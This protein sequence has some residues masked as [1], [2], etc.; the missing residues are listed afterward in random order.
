MKKTLK[1]CLRNHTLAKVLF[2]VIVMALNGFLTVSAYD[3]SSNGIY[4]NIL[5]E[6]NLTCEV[7]FRGSTCNEYYEYIG[8]IS[9]P[10][11]V[12]YGSKVYK[13]TA[14]G[15]EAFH[16]N[17]GYGGL[18]SISIPNTIETIGYNALSC[19]FL[20]TV[21]IPESVTSIGDYAFVECT[22]LSTVY[23]N[24]TNCPKM[25]SLRYP[26]F[27]GCKKLTNV[28][29]GKNV[30]IIPDYGFYNCTNLNSIS[31]PDSVNTIG[32]RAFAGCS[33]L[34]SIKMSNSVIAIDSYAFEDCNFSSVTLPNSLKK[35]GTGAFRNCNKITSVTIPE[36]VD[37][38][39]DENNSIGAFEGCSGL[40]TVGFN[41]INCVGG[42]VFVD[43]V[44]ME[45]VTIGDKV[46]SIP[47]YCFSGCKSLPSITIPESVTTIGDKAFY[48][49][50]ALETINFNAVDCQKMGRSDYLVFG[51][52]SAIKNINI[53]K[54]VKVIPN[55]AFYDCNG[56]E[57][58]TLPET[59]TQIGS[60][61]FY[62]LDKISLITFP[63]TLT[64]IG[65]SAFQYCSNLSSVIIP[66]MVTIIGEKAFYGCS[67]LRSLTIGVG[68]TSIGY[69]AF[70]NP[71]K[72]IWLTNVPPTGYTNAKGGVNIVPN[73]SYSSFTNVSVYPYISSMFEI[74]GIKYVPVSPSERTCDIVDCLYDTTMTT[75]SI[76]P[77]IM[78]KGIEMR[79]N[80]INMSAF[81]KN[82]YIKSVEI[83]FGG[84]IGKSAFSNCN[85][86]DNVVVD[87]S[88]IGY[89]AFYECGSL[90]NVI[91]G[92]DV[93]TVGDNSFSDCVNLNSLSFGE[94]VKVVG[95]N[96]FSGCS[97]LKDV[98][99]GDKVETI[100]DFAFSNCSG[101]ERL[102][103]GF[104]MRNIGNQA[105]ADCIS[106]VKIR[107]KAT[108]PP[109]CG[110]QALSDINKWNCEL[111]VPDAS[112]ALY[113][114]AD[115]WKD[116][117]YIIPDGVDEVEVD[118]NA[119]E[120]ERYDI[121]GRL[122]IEPTKGINIV[123]MSDG[124]IKKELREKNGLERN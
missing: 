105:F 34:T 50:T 45:T 86:I 27:K 71:N 47:S 5:S 93:D 51:G 54:N 76:E 79:L 32:V 66:D 85:S 102:E 63:K 19:T 15:N 69:L 2:A 83:T 99:F 77:K 24:A 115:Q 117:F 58:I 90:K 29:F 43:C 60:F 30:K 96:A 40:K 23:F 97:E 94:N 41:A 28:V 39:G 55:Y 72:T 78:Y 110:A 22:S 104:N 103:F 49:C 18:T 59:L 87:A 112:V 11:Q 46:Q 44:A 3:F 101:L 65:N 122:L 74:D 116:F 91:I 82:K 36:S 118:G 35:I 106:L 6:E 81:I 57:S 20:K 98:V 42:Y 88:T 14:I 56:V 67:S 80:D 108:T 121:H 7:T 100:G 107:S 84:N 4:Y 64:S 111:M 62:G 21:T 109:V 113:Q 114:A 89:Y 17:N 33:G 9:I 61:A 73:D 10:E 12:T 120:V 8:H 16:G 48:S 26:A 92:N 75:I 37:S 123:K 13:V 124:T 119:V 53:G 52:C 31:L 70:S 95:N 1:V 68:V 38:I 25:G